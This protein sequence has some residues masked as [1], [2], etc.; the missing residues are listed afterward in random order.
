MVKHDHLFLPS[1]FSQLPGILDVAMTRSSLR[2][3]N[4][5]LMQ[6]DLLLTLSNFDLLLE[7]EISCPSSTHS[8]CIVYSRTFLGVELHNLSRVFQLGQISWLESFFSDFDGRAGGFFY[9]IFFI[10][11]KQRGEGGSAVII[12]FHMH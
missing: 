8:L 10:C 2:I 5:I 6:L 4:T 9:F 1:G 12:L 3:T 7:M 11:A